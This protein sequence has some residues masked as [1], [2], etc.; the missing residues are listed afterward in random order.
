V[1]EITEVPPPPATAGPTP[2]AFL[3]LFLR[4]NRFLLSRLLFSCPTTTTSRRRAIPSLAW[5]LGEQAHPGRRAV[6]PRGD[7]GA[8]WRWLPRE[9]Q[10]ARLLLPLPLGVIAVAAGGA[11]PAATAAAAAR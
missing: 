5:G 7:A 11:A 1:R 6:D 4:L 8:T 10:G 2:H 9:A 3:P